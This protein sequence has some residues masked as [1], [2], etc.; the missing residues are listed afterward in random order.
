MKKSQLRK[1]I[2]ESIKQLITEQT[3]QF[4]YGGNCSGKTL[5]PGYIHGS[6]S[7]QSIYDVIN[8]NYGPNANWLDYVYE[9]EDTTANIQYMMDNTSAC[10]AS[11][12]TIYQSSWFFYSVNQ[13][14]WCGFNH[15][16]NFQQFIDGLNNVPNSPGTFTTGMTYSQAR[17]LAIANNIG[18][19]LPSNFTGQFCNNCDYGYRC[20]KSEIKPGLSLNKCVPGTAQNPG[21][22]LTLQD[23]LDSDCE[24]K[25]ADDDLEKDFT[26]PFTTTPQSKMADPKITDPQIDRMQDLA[27]RKR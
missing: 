5:I 14:S 9:L 11:P 10:I 1:I 24:L 2:R 23:C 21:P 6:L 7:T 15:V 8:Q 19:C 18:G 4:P 16:Y 12:T 22:F 27:N 17:T 20:G 25:Q 13:P 26:T 3:N